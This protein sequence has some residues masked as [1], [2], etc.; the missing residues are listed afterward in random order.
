MYWQPGEYEPRPYSEMAPHLRAIDPVLDQRARNPW[1][2]RYE[3][4]LPLDEFVGYIPGE[5]AFAAAVNGQLGDP[6]R[7]LADLEAASAALDIDLSTRRIA[8]TG[9]P[10]LGITQNYHDLDIVFRGNV[11]ENREVADAIRRYLL[12]RPEG[13]VHEGGKSW[14]VRFL[15]PDR[16][17]EQR[18]ICCFFV[19]G[20]PQAAPL[21][22]LSTEV[23]DEDVTLTGT[24]ANANEAVY[25]PTLV[26][27]E[28]V[29]AERS[30]SEVPARLTL[31]VH[32]TASRGELNDGDSVWARGALVDLH[33]SRGTERA[34]CVIEREGVRNETPPW[35]GYYTR[36]RYG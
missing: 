31:V 7:V 23:I 16:N 27:L 26:R 18:L 9:T 10:A 22:D 30:S 35:A 33:S 13:R 24:V 14:L 36:E 19:Y 1:P 29:E 8:L 4:I 17:G 11:E 34:L 15:A 2:L 32:H 25:T 3:Q 6:S 21:R 5:E 28:A 20:D 12:E